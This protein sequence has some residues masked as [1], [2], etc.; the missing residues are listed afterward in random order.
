[1]IGDAQETWNNMAVTSDEY[2]D[3]LCRFVDHIV[4]ANLPLRDANLTEYLKYL[5]L[6]M[7][8]Y[9]CMRSNCG[10]GKS[11]FLIDAHGDVYPCAHSAGIPEWRV[12]AIEDI[13]G[14]LVERGRHNRIV[15]MLEKRRVERISGMNTCPWRHFCEGGC[16][17]NAYQK[18][19]TVLGPDTLCSF[20][21]RLY[22]HLFEMLATAPARF[23]RLLDL[24]LG[25]GR[26]NVVQFEINPHEANPWEYY[27]SVS[28]GEGA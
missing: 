14:D 26:V 24:M 28:R 20:Y 25:S 1:M 13:D 12:A 6:R 15:H 23:Q 8:N 22:P 16:A 17:V 21:E 27:R 10:A 4:G 19:G 11:F 3:F 7:H 18:F 5:V 2:F 9:R